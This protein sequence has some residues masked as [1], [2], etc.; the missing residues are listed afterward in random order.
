[1]SLEIASDFVFLPCIEAGKKSSVDLETAD[2]SSQLLLEILPSEI[3]CVDG[4]LSPM[5]L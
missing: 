1:M 3:L 5:L 2:H 4:V